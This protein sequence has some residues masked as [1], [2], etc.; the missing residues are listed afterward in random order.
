MIIKD[1]WKCDE[2]D[3][4]LQRCGNHSKRLDE[5]RSLKSWE[6]EHF[7][8]EHS[9]AAWIV[10]TTGSNRLVFSVHPREICC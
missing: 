9:Q 1:F 2:S 3:I 8:S 10:D 4:P 7:D 6:V 5:D